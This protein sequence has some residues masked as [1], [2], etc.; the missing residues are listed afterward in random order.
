MTRISKQ[1]RRRNQ[2]PRRPKLGSIKTGPKK[3]QLPLGFK[4]HLNALP[5]ENQTVFI[6]KIKQV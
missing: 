3:D 2:S 6:S 5:N 4:E 1:G